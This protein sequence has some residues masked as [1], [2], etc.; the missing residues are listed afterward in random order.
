MSYGTGQL[1]P[2]AGRSPQ[3]DRRADEQSASRLED[4]ETGRYDVQASPAAALG[5]QPVSV[6]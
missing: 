4:G 2:C 5:P 3:M 1:L 6:L